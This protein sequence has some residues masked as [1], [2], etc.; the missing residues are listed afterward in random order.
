MNPN[1]Q[2]TILRIRFGLVM[3]KDAPYAGCYHC[4]KMKPTF[5]HQIQNPFYRKSNHPT[6]FRRIPASVDMSTISAQGQPP[7]ILRQNR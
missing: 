5:P 3:L 1:T 4:N 7:G 6:A 2:D